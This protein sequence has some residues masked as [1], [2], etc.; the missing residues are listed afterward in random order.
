MVRLI[1]KFSLLMSW[2]GFLFKSIWN[3]Y[4]FLSLR[5][6][7]VTFKVSILRNLRRFSFSSGERFATTLGSHRRGAG[8]VL[9]KMLFNLLGGSF[10]YGSFVLKTVAS[11][12]YVLIVIIR[13]PRL[14]C[15]LKNTS[16]RG[17]SHTIL[18]PSIRLKCSMSLKRIHGPNCSFKPRIWHSSP[19][20][21]YLCFHNDFLCSKLIAFRT[22]SYI[23]HFYGP[24]DIDLS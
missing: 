5:W 7:I 15:P 9:C 14:K 6:W 11:R 17:Q 2:S 1:I 21:Q 10:G 22:G 3:N 16:V 4:I 19:K 8:T 13:Y 24:L 18:K 20:A 12:K 23:V